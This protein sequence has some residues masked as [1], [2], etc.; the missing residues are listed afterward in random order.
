MSI[1]KVVMRYGTSGTSSGGGSLPRL[2]DS[3]DLEYESTVEDTILSL[4]GGVAFMFYGVATN[5]ASGAYASM[6]T[7]QFTFKVGAKPSI[8]NI[9]SDGTQRVSLAANDDGTITLK[10]SAAT[11]HVRYALYKMA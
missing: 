10:P 9:L 7:A 3:G 11:Y 5:K 1:P 2:I 6:R 4:D 8:Q